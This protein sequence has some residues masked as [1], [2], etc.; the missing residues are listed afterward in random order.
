MIRLLI[1]GAIILF[2]VIAYFANTDTNPVTGEAQRVAGLSTKDEIVLGLQAEGEMIREFGGVFPDPDAQARVDFVG[3]RLLN[4]FDQ[5]LRKAGRSNPYDFEFTLLA[6]PKT[7]NAFALPGGR[8]FITYALY[9]RLTS[10]DQLAGVLAHE[11]GHVL[12]RHGAQ[13]IAKQQLTQGVVGATG[14]AMG[15]QQS[16]Q[17][18]QMVGAFINMKYGRD[19]ELESDRWSVRLTLGAGYDPE[20]MIHVMDILEQAAGGGNPPEFL[21]THPSP[22][23]RREKIREAI[24]ELRPKTPEY[25]EYQGT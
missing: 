7:V 2:S 5:Q 6:D 25:D 21:S 12:E 18:A 13:R 17:I 3:A 24:E 11:I 16:M 9:S 22:E 8:V 14:V 1:A 19:D 4:A 23:N 10:E 15:D 20:A